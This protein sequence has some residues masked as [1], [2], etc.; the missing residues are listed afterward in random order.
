MTIRNYD[1]SGKKIHKYFKKTP[2]KEVF[3]FD[4]TPKALEKHPQA[5]KKHPKALEK[6]KAS[7]NEEPKI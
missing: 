6:H 5:L 4:K 2:Q 1:Q 7:A 3:C